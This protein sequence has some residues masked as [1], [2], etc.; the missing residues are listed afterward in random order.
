MQAAWFLVVHVA[1][2]RVLQCRFWEKIYLLKG[3][4]LCC[5]CQYRRDF[6]SGLELRLD[7]ISEDGIT[8]SISFMV[9]GV[10]G[11]KRKGSLT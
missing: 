3:F 8:L 11:V 4:D 7:P 2:E 6:S 5:W 1:C 10:Y 9:A